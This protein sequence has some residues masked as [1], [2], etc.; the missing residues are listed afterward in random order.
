M[1]NSFRVPFLTTKDS[2]FQHY[3][4]KRERRIV[5]ELIRKGHY[6]LAESKIVGRRHYDIFEYKKHPWGGKKSWYNEKECY[7]DRKN[8]LN[9]LAVEESRK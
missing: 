7:K 3:H 9:K 5:K 8:F 2:F 1:T 6:E 4:N